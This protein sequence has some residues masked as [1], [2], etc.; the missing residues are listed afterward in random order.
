ME[1][2]EPETARVSQPGLRG[3]RVTIVGGGLAGMAAALALAERGAQVDI[4]D[5]ASRLGGKAG[6]DKHG[7][8]YDDHGYHVFPMW[9]LN[10]WK[11][12]EELRIAGHFV[13]APVY[14]Q[15]DKQ[16]RYQTV[17][18]FADYRY[19]WSNLRAGVLPLPEAFLFVFAVL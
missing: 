12:I 3:R 7:E 9:Y 4:F 15:L 6:S 5:E 11:L 14:R 1:R 19:F 13:D 10:A 17:T 18:N 2:A 16:H 8:D